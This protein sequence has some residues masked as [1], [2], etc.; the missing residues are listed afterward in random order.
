MH[1]C[2]LYRRRISSTGGN[3]CWSRRSELHRFCDITG[4]SLAIRCYHHLGSCEYHQ[5]QTTQATP[6]KK[7]H[8]KRRV[9]DE[10]WLGRG[11]RDTS[12]YS[13]INIKV[14]N[15][16]LYTRCQFARNITS[17]DAMHLPFKW[18]PMSQKVH[19]VSL[20]DLDLWPLTLKTFPADN[21]RTAGQH[22]LK[23]NALKSIC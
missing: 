20:Y 4:D 11:A 7:N 5:Q 14:D 6:T 10:L 9:L 1:S 19:L 21:G 2:W 23:H 13:V 18:K 3:S 12:S 22:P 15:T 17:L 8:K 16:Q